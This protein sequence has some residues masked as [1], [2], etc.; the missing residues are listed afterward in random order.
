MEL[1]VLDRLES[2][3]GVAPIFDTVGIR[4]RMASVFI[5]FGFGQVNLPRRLDC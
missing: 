5:G 1:I 3:I 4:Y 2:D